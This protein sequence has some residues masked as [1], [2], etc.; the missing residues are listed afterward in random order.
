MLP[1]RGAAE[2]MDRR[3]GDLSAARQTWIFMSL[4]ERLSRQSRRILESTPSL[5]IFWLK[6]LPSAPVIG[7][8]SP[9]MVRP[10][11]TE[12]E[13]GPERKPELADRARM[14]ILSTPPLETQTL[15]VEGSLCTRLFPQR[16]QQD[17]S[18]VRS[19]LRH[20]G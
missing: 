9:M 1:F 11:Q 10:A 8:K 5:T 6:S 12:F 18:Q 7:S 2:R 3:E 20:R 4:P 19:L 16:I 13:L 14:K 17:G 15:F